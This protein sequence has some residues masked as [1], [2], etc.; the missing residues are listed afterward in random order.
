[1]MDEKL[2]RQFGADYCCLPD[3]AADRRNHF[4]EHTFLPGRRTWQE[5]PECFLKLAV[6]N[7][8]LLFTGRKDIIE[9]CSGEFAESGP[10]WFLEAETLRKLDARLQQDGHRI[11]LIHLYY[12][13]DRITPVSTD[14]YEIRWYY[15]EEIEQFRGDSRFGEAFAFCETAPDIIGVSAVRDGEILGMAGASCDSPLMRQIGINVCPGHRNA[16]IGTML[17]ALLKNRILEQGLLPY[18]GTSISHTASQRTA[19]GAGLLPAWT[20]LFTAKIS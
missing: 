13:A 20:E 14:G 6:F 2:Y 5:E 4:T 11:D 16:G 10:E 15:N 1:M 18:Y 19:V 7:G 9:W 17:T 3:E 12:T 8:K